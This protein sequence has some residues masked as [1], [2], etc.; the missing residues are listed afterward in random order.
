MI[1]AVRI[2]SAFGLFVHYTVIPV[3]Y[4]S[5]GHNGLKG[6]FDD[7]EPMVNT[8]FKVFCINLNAQHVNGMTQIDLT[9]CLKIT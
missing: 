1:D 6:Q 8:K 5:N 4:L 7:V 3:Q 2:K 9:Q